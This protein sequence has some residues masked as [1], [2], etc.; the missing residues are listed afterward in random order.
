MTAEPAPLG[1]AALVEQMW[2]RFQPLAAARVNALESHA[3]A[4]GEGGDAAEQLLRPA[5]VSAAHNLEGSLGSYARPEGS[6][7][8][9]V[10]GAALRE[11]QPDPAVL[12]T[13]SKQLRALVGP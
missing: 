10:Y 1:V 7:L 2:S 6:R 11:A 8:A 12:L 5:A 3:M 4:V 13:V 9:A